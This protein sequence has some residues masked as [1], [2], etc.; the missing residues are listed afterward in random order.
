MAIPPGTPGKESLLRLAVSSAHTN[1]DIDRL[2]AAYGA[3]ADAFPIAKV[4]A[5]AS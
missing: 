2:V 3:M 5:G 1:D 4:T